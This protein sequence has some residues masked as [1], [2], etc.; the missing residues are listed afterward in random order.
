MFYEC[1]SL[2]ALPDISIWNASNVN[3]MNSMFYECKK[4]LNIPSKF[5]K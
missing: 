2:S 4:L 1:S 5:N 3:N